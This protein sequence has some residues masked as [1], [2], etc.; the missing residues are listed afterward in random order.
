MSV[1]RTTWD[2]TTNKELFKTLVRKDFDSTAREAVVESERL[3]NMLTTDDLYERDMR[4]AGLPTGREVAEGAE[5]LIYKP[6]MGTTKD[7]TQAKYGLGFRV[8]DEMKRFN[9]WNLVKK[10]TRSLSLKQKELKDIEMAKLWNSPTSTYTGF[11]TLALG[12]ASHTCLDDAASTYDNLISAALSITGLES[13]KYYFEMLK[14]DQGATIFLKPDLLYYHPTLEFTVNEI[15][16]S[17][18]KPH[19]IS[20]TYNYWKGKFEPYM[21]HRLTSTTAWGL[22]AKG[23][24]LYDINCFTATEPDINTKDAPDQ[25]RDTIVDSLQYFTWGFGDPRAVCI[26]NT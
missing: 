16:K 5:I 6:K 10:W 25:T 15:L 9:K 24:D 12:H 3:Y 13:A 18:G 11:D 8:T 7:Y 22:L 23:S 17:D 21:Y 2:T 14:D 20:N 26:G 4:Y 19:E 1:I